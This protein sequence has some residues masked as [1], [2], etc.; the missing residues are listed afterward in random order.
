MRLTGYTSSAAS[1][2]RNTGATRDSDELFL[3]K[4]VQP[5][6][7]VKSVS[8]TP[9]AFQEAACAPVPSALLQ[10]F[11]YEAKHRLLEQF[12]S[13]LLQP[14]GADR[15]THT[16]AAATNRALMNRDFLLVLVGY[17]GGWGIS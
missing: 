2:C 17:G 7:S 9:N 12:L 16:A 6:A 4:G 8:G 11:S 15:T 3:P 13:D 5:P 14:Y 1:M 10:Q